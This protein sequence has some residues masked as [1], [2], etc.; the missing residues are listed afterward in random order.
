MEESELD[1]WR[2]HF[3]VICCHLHTGTD[4]IN[5]IY[6]CVTLFHTRCQHEEQFALYENTAT[7]LFPQELIVIW[8]ESLELWRRVFRQESPDVSKNRV[9][10]S[11][12]EI[13]SS[14]ES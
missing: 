4:K 9:T 12:S 10:A 13:L 1:C 5:D 2:L 3:A 14:P 8:I 11:S 7:V 6:R